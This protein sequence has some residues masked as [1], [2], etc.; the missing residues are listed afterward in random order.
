[1]PVGVDGTGRVFRRHGPDVLGPGRAAA[2]AGQRLGRVGRYGGAL[3][4]E[5]DRDLYDNPRRAGAVVTVVT[6]ETQ[7]T[8]RELAEQHLKH[9]HCRPD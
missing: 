2:L 3:R 5:Q 4:A 7:V 8:V 1:M 6:M 9:P